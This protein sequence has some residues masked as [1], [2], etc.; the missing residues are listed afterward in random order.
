MTDDEQIT[1][2]DHEPKPTY[3]YRV[4]LVWDV[5]G[6]FGSEVKAVV[7][8]SLMQAIEMVAEGNIKDLTQVHATALCPDSYSLIEKMD[9]ENDTRYRYTGTKE[10][11]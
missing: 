8:E 9:E 2:Y 6:S 10:S 5:P 3:M 11:E 4:R 1:Y 7:A